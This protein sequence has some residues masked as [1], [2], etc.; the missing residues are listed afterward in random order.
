MNQISAKTLE[1]YIRERFQ[2]IT[3][4]VAYQYGY[5]T[6]EGIYYSLCEL[7]TLAD[8]FCYYDLKKQLDA[9]VEAARAKMLNR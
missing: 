3:N 8:S 5:T 9:A 6:K 1:A 4:P 2:A 7:R